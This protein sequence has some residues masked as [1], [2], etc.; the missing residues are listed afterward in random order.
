MGSTQAYHE[1]EFL[2]E[3]WGL[4]GLG[5]LI[6]FLRFATRLRTVGVRQSKGDDYMAIVVLFCYTADAVTGWSCPFF[7]YSGGREVVGAGS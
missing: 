4:Y 2:R 6:L 1:P 3:V 5:V 7:G